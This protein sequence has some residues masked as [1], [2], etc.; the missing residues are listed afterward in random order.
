[1]SYAGFV[2]ASAYF[3]SVGLISG[4]LPVSSSLADRLPFHSPVFGG[5]ALACVVAA[6]ATVVTALA[7]RGDPRV[8]EAA[9]LAGLLLAGWIV[10]E[11]A[12]I[13]EFS[14]LQVVFGLAGVGLVLVGERRTAPQIAEPKARG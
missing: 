11:V 9:T 4:L 5:V 12:V 2:A 6:P 10:V 3:G 7:W 8:R 1:M 14:P 13:R